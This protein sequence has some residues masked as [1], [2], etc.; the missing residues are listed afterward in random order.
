MPFENDSEA[1]LVH[2]KAAGRTDMLAVIVF[3]REDTPEH[4]NITDEDGERIPFGWR[5]TACR[6]VFYVAEPSGL[7]HECNDNQP[8]IWSRANIHISE[9]KTA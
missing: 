6:E 7:A 8:V 2:Y 5:C 3:H 1:V 9:G 4:L